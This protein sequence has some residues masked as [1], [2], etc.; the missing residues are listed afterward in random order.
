MK[1]MFYEANEVFLKHC[2]TCIVVKGGVHAIYTQ[3]T[4]Q[5]TVGWCMTI[6]LHKY[7]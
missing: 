6:S 2:A 5:N 1:V 3:Q 4:R 7:N